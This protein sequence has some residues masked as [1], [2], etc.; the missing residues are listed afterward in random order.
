MFKTSPIGLV[1]AEYVKP[2]AWVWKHFAKGFRD[3]LTLNK[4][5]KPGT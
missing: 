3:L 2:A 1:T 4:P 5:N